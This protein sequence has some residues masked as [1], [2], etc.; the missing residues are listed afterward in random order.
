MER[1]E[2]ELFKAGDYKEKG[3][4]SNDD[5]LKIVSTVKAEGY[6]IPIGIGHTGDPDAP[7]Y[8]LLDPQ[9]LLVEDGSIWGRVKTIVPE[10]VQAMKDGVYSKWSA[11]LSDRFKDGC[12]G[13]SRLD[14]L[15]SV[16][17]EIKSLKHRYGFSE[18]SETKEIRIDFS[19]E[20]KMAKKQQEQFAEEQEQEEVEEVKEEDFGKML[21]ELKAQFEALKE[22]LEA[23][24]K[25][26]APEEDEEDGEEVEYSETDKKVKSLEKAL[27]QEKQKRIQ[28]EATA[29]AES[30]SGKIAR[31]KMETVKKLY[32]SL[33]GQKEFSEGSSLV[34]MLRDVLGAKIAVPNGSVHQASFSE[35]KSKEDQAAEGMASYSKYYEGGV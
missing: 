17:P 23:L 15:G 1:L 25:E 3:S 4:Y 28:T 22:E 10:L 35:T 14:F 12:L 2:L 24:K 34:D 31:D 30:F 32:A 6:E 20:E 5:L 11:V 26:V 16:P 33:E 7:A 13:I 8:G 9:T 21:A 19:Q 29:F 27:S 18:D